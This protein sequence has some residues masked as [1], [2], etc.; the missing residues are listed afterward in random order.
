MIVRDAVADERAGA[1]KIPV[2]AV[3]RNPISS[4]RQHNPY[5]KV[6]QVR[7]RSIVQSATEACIHSMRIVTNRTRNIRCEMAA[8]TA[9]ARSRSANLFSKARIAED[10]IPVV[11]SITQRVV[12]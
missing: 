8:V 12:G 7:M 9:T 2:I 11:T 10:A 5:I 4:G 1:R 6:D 3:N